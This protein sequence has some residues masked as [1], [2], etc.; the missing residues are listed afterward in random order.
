MWFLP[1]SK[2][3]KLPKEV[4]NVLPTQI[5]IRTPLALFK[6]AST[7]SNKLLPSVI[8]IERFTMDKEC[9]HNAG[10][11][12]NLFTKYGSDKTRHNYHH[13]YGYILSRLP[14]DSRILE[15]GIGSGNP[16]IVSNMGPN[17]KPGA[18]MNAFKSFSPE[19]LV[20]GADIDDRL[21]IEGFKLFNIDQTKPE[22][23]SVIAKEGEPEYDLIIDDG[24]HSPD[25]NLF[26]LEFALNCISEKGFIVIED[27]PERTIVIWKI[28]Q[29]L[30][31]GSQYRTSIVKGKSLY[32][33]V[34]T[35]SDSTLIGSR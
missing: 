13:L 34:C 19:S 18:S 14:K 5:A 35:K 8:N 27:I 23:F 3:T 12:S 16:N 26:T 11:I 17:A 31:Q 28:V 32:L 1:T 15:I 21:K 20:H 6:L 4:Q 22:S 29:F 30:M 9:N 24:M 33:F 10:I 7:L 2:I 25:A